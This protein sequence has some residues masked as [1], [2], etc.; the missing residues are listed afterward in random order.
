MKERKR[1]LYCNVTIIFRVVFSTEYAA[2]LPFLHKEKYSTRFI[3][4]S[5]H[6]SSPNN[7]QFQEKRKCTK[8]NLHIFSFIFFSG[9]KSRSATEGRI[10]GGCRETSAAFCNGRISGGR[11]PEVY[12]LEGP[13]IWT[14]QTPK[15]QSKRE[16]K[17][18]AELSTLVENFHWKCFP[19]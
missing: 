15:N 13:T 1:K 19:E 4:M 12:I 10:S 5:F 17:T 14:N 2:C 18:N 3:F 11:E 9:R 7:S 16:K 8:K 6:F